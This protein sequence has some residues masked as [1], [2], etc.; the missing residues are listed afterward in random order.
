[1]RHAMMTILASMLATCILF[2]G[3]PARAANGEAQMDDD[4]RSGWYEL[5][6]AVTGFTLSDV[7]ADQE[8]LRG[9]ELTAGPDSDFHIL[10]FSDDHTKFLVYFTDVKRVKDVTGDIQYVAEDTLYE[11]DRSRLTPIYYRR[12][13]ISHGLLIIPFKLRMEDKSLTG[14]S[15]IG[16]YIGR[17]EEHLQAGWNWVIAGGLTLIPVTDAGGE[18]E[19]KTGATLAVGWI[20]KTIDNFQLGA[21]A[22]VDHIGGSAGESWKFE[23][24]P[25]VS[26][27]I[28]FE[29]SD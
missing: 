15:T 18:T 16:Y 4:P 11:I 25:W 3:T 9:V 7:R 14:Q 22:G 19:E 26:L 5:R 28:G 20:L 2:A 29:F 6:L 1:M 24:D 8:A 27:S 21:F 13:R 17:E 12:W 10:G 23:D